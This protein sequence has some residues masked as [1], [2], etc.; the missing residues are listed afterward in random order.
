[1]PYLPE[2]MLS[3][4][5]IRI[6]VDYLNSQRGFLFEDCLADNEAV[7]F[8]SPQRELVFYAGG[9]VED[10]FLQIESELKKGNCLAGY[11]SYEFGYI[12]EPKLHRYLSAS[13]LPLAWLGV[14]DKFQDKKEILSHH[15]PV[16]SPSWR[17]GKIV[18]SLSFKEYYCHFQQIREYIAD[19]ESYEVN[20]TF[21]QRF[22]LRG[23][24][25]SFFV[26]L[27]RAQPVKYLAFVNDGQRKVLSF[28][29][30]LFFSRRQRTIT[31][32]P[33]KGTARRGRFIEEDNKIRSYLRNDEKNQAENL[34]VL[35]ML[36]NDLGRIAE[37]GSVK[38]KEL[39][40]L[41]KLR[42]LWQMVSVVEACLR[43]DVG[44]YDIFR[45][46]FPSGSVTGAPKV[47]TMEII[48]EQEGERRGVY[49][50]AI[51]YILPSQEA[52]FNV[53]IRTICLEGKK[54]TLG[55]GSGLVYDSTA[56]EEYKECLAKAAFLEKKLPPF[57]LIESLRL[58]QGQYFLLPLHLRRLQ[59]S[60][61]Y[62]QIP[63]AAEKIENALFSLAVKLKRRR[64]YKVRLLL[65]QEGKLDITWQELR[66]LSLP[67]RVKI[68]E[69]C[70]DSENVFLYHK[71]TQRHL[72]Q[73]EL[74]K[75]QREGFDEVIF[76]NQQGEITEG[77]FTN[78][79]LRQDGLIYTPPV[80]SGLLNGVLRR[81]LMEKG[82]VQEKRLSHTDMENCQGVYLGNAVRGLMPAE[83]FVPLVAKV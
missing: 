25:A 7:I 34:M 23:S 73:Q 30:E 50:G 46:L 1:M 63:Y 82:L 60:A 18:P 37:A 47:R 83:I 5:E 32:M 21:R 45:A 29:P 75:A 15:H 76:L 28:S 3:E 53:A 39:F 20:F 55:I 71:T 9:K 65:S 79:F 64:M 68:S 44:Y 19:G 78:I 35:D 66:R 14:F 48:A 70:I 2:I 33:M 8:A 61:A 57:S 40:R 11:F 74:R 67:L 4:N 49:T 72:Y 58:Y 52:V 10:F 77:S 80:R 42:S 38:V 51:G 41:E 54:A 22:D 62:F 36:R 59:E 81:Y 6:L 16:L 56:A 24:L 69:C 43:I 31:V 26:D 27:R 12:F 13:S 17:R